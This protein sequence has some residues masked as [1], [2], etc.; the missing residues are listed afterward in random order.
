VTRVGA[1]WARPRS[2]GWTRQAGARYRSAMAFTC[3][4]CAC[5]NFREVVVP[6]GTGYYKTAFFECCTCSVMF[7]DPARFSVGRHEKAE[8]E[9]AE[10]NRPRS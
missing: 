3:P 6:K 7:R 9:Y 10:R 8:R 2:T 1:P 5:I 4:I